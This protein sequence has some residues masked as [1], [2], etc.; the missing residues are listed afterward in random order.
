MRRTGGLK[1]TRRPNGTGAIGKNGYLDMRIDGRRVNEHILVAERALGKPLPK[2]SVVHH[3]NQNKLDNRPNN[4]A[5]FP[6][7]AYHKL[8][9][10]RMAARD[11]C[12]NPDW[13]KCWIC[14]KWDEPSTLLGTNGRPQRWHS[15]C[16]RRY[17]QKLYLNKIGRCE[18]P[19]KE[20][21]NELVQK[22]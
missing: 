10:M 15:V 20:L 21:R 5:I 18:H 12:G 17:R 9:H 8:I 2:G 1:I 4:L 6:N 13:R 16:A 7:E 19:L 14:G 22:P 11:I 3:A